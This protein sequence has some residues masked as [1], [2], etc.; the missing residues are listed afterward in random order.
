MRDRS[1]CMSLRIDKW[2][3]FTRL[4]KTRSQAAKACSGGRVHVNQER[5]KS[6]RE[7]R[8][9]DIIDLT[10]DQYAYRFSVLGFPRHRGPASVA[11]TFYSEDDEVRQK[12]EA[13][14]AARRAVRAQMPTTV[15]KPDKKTR[16]ALR[17]W[18]SGETE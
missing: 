1:D 2:L 14:S 16:R 7:L 15:G 6:S 4:Y 18:K 13:D 5:V 9:G 17:A 8:E 12:R 3:F 11:Q 10:R